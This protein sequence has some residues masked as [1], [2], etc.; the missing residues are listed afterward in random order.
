MA[1]MHLKEFPTYGLPRLEHIFPLNTAQRSVTAPRNRMTMAG[2]AYAERVRKEEYFEILDE[3]IRTNP[4][5][6]AAT[7]MASVMSKHGITSNTGN[8]LG[9]PPSLQ[10]TSTA[11]EKKC[12]LTRAVKLAQN[13]G[14][15]LNL[16]KE[17][18]QVLCSEFGKKPVAL[19]SGISPDGSGSLS[20]STSS[21]DKA[22]LIGHL[23]TLIGEAET[24][25]RRIYETAVG[26]HIAEDYFRQPEDLKVLDFSNAGRIQIP[27]YNFN[28]ASQLCLEWLHSTALKWLR[29]FKDEGEEELG[30][31]IKLFESFTKAVKDYTEAVCLANQVFRVLLYPNT[32]GKESLQEYVLAMGHLLK[33]DVI[34]EIQSLRRAF[35]NIQYTF[36]RVG[37]AASIA[38]MR[39]SGK[40]VTVETLNENGLQ[41]DRSS[42]QHKFYEGPPKNKWKK[43]DLDVKSK[44]GKKLVSLNGNYKGDEGTTPT[45]STAT[46]KT[47]PRKNSSQVTTKCHPRGDVETLS[48]EILP[49]NALAQQDL[50]KVFQQSHNAI[51]EEVALSR[52]SRSTPD[53]TKK[54]TLK[55]KLQSKKTKMPSNIG[56][57]NMVPSTTSGESQVDSN[58]ATLHHTNSVVSDEKVVA[59]KNS[60]KNQIRKV[61]KI[62]RALREQFNAVFGTQVMAMKAVKPTKEK[63]AGKTRAKRAGETNKGQDA[64]VTSR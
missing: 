14:Q 7:A 38:W 62:P 31:F 40:S 28:H 34:M 17:D 58:G 8:V 30:E 29:G 55:K 50:T 46:F 35:D 41:V 61:G 59:S 32:Q 16:L 3:T 60:S 56:A 42:F 24:I 37:W 26:L 2:N 57:L 18:L 51:D 54:K 25:A 64:T 43:K 47:V 27:N 53:I 11:P 20:F 36:E 13:C 6:K 23:V 1:L 9:K 45:S 33:N 10:Q 44:K 39:Y 5:R 15:K 21:V 22:T 19:P 49:K 52:R 48:S 4:Y 63:K 12:A